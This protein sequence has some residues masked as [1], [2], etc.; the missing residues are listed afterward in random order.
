MTKSLLAASA[1]LTVALSANQAAAQM[2][3][4]VGGQLDFEA[5]AAMSDDIGATGSAGIE[6]AYLLDTFGLDAPGSV[7]DK[8]ESL[9][10]ITGAGLSAALDEDDGFAGADYNPGA[11]SV[12]ATDAER[13]GDFRNRADNVTIS[14]SNTV[15]NG[16]T[17]GGSYNILKG[18][19]NASAQLFLSG[20]FGTVRMGDWDAAANELGIGSPSAGTGGFDGNWGD[21]VF[22]AGIIDTGTAGADGTNITYLTSGT[23][24]DDSGVTLGLSYTPQT[25]SNDWTIA[26]N[27]ED[28]FQDAVS[29][30]VQYQ[31][32]FS[33]VSLSGSAGYEFGTSNERDTFRIWQPGTNLNDVDA[34]GNP[35]NDLEF[36]SQNLSAFQLGANLGVG[37]F[38]VGAQYVDNRDSGKPSGSTDRTWSVGATYTVGPWGFGINYADAEEKVSVSRDADNGASFTV[39]ERVVGLGGSYSVAP[40]LDILSDLTHFRSDWTSTRRAAGNEDSLSLD[41]AGWV[42]LVSTRLSF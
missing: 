9:D 25:G 1:L 21:Y 15:D 19:T 27:N 22:N 11:E 10:E 36:S 30:A 32:E 16:L 7:Q 17:Y 29:A 6:G 20:A 23:A 14:V 33:G 38:T 42:G 13:S 28:G 2:E 34:D 40:G 35:V 5:G 18:E 8:Q 12:A 24:L 37:G 41:N 4:S 39:S 26:R 31:G 3:V